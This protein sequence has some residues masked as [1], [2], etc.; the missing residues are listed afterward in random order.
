MSREA[1]RCTSDLKESMATLTLTKS[2][3]VHRIVHTMGQA[4]QTSGERAKLHTP[5]T[6][7]QATCNGNKQNIRK[8]S[9]LKGSRKR[10]GQLHLFQ[11]L[12]LIFGSCPVRFARPQHPLQVVAVISQNSGLL[13]DITGIT[14]SIKAN[15]RGYWFHLYQANSESNV[16]TEQ[17]CQHK[18][19]S[20]PTPVLALPT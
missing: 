6:A 2:F 13:A 9:F 3:L 11:T 18:P 1:S 19:S 20:K 4:E 10:S 15:W 16:F 12:A 5:C 8:P 7:L 17:C 14:K